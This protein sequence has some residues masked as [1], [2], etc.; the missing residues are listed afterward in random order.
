[1]KKK[2]K[3]YVRK[4]YNCKEK[5]GVLDYVAKWF[6]MTEIAWNLGQCGT[7]FTLIFQMF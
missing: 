7:R 6:Q 3:K 2:K 1:M 4:V 5:M